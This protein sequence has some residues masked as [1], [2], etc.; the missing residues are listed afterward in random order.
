MAREAAGAEG[1]DTRDERPEQESTGRLIVSGGGSTLVGTDTL[2]AQETTMRMLHS[3]ALN[4]QARLTRI[5]GLT[6]APAPAWSPRDPGV[7]VLSA[8]IAID[9]V[10]AESQRLADA[11]NAAAEG[12][13]RAERQAEHA[14]L[15]TGSTLGWM[16]GRFPQL[17]ALVALSA[18]PA[19][20]TGVVIWLL[21]QAVTA[22][23]RPTPATD[24][25]GGFDVDPRLLTSPLA[26]AL[27]R[28][29]VSSLDDVAAGAI[30]LPLPV[31]RA[32]GEDGIGLLGVTTSA[33]GVLAVARPHGLLRETPV[34]VLP[35][36][37]G[38]SSRAPRQGLPVSGGRAGHPVPGRTPD[39]V[40]ASPPAGLA[41][42]AARIPDLS[43][44]GGQV[45]V[46]RY[47][48]DGS[49]AWVVYIGG[50]VDWS[51]VAAAEPWDLTSNLAAVAEEE[52]GSY[53]AVVQAMREAG[54][55]PGEPVIEVGHSQGGLI[56]AQVA[57][58]GEFTS[59]ATVTFGA[60]SGSVPVP[61]GVDTV[62]VEHTDDI[63]PGM[64]G[65][66]D[67]AT[68]R[69]LVRR[70]VFAS[71]PL[72]DGVLLPAHSMSTYQET[73]RLI[74]SSPEPRLHAFRE[75]LVQ[76]VGTTDGRAGIWRGTRSPVN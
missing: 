3:A 7:D 16:I 50:T 36:G 48:G 55:R 6:V 43:T 52:S 19:L 47:G 35:G 40:R 49:A 44:E 14:A 74:D 30:G 76:V 64:G 21:R 69:L 15:L 65:T 51:P 12:Y 70:E 53:R 9:V 60:P 5:R 13:A 4:W 31:A 2:L 29:T 72:P 10:E 11:L 20:T 33:A 24:S 1:R 32:I 42:L 66:S 68:G 37:P 41:E 17:A 56:A 23:G 46:E 59:V 75:Q 54:I 73:A 58:S 71:D 34:T 67:A 63:V 26:A 45:R 22:P 18:M 62:A 61:A 28:A 39:V 38:G 27:V 8:T 57:A 25:S